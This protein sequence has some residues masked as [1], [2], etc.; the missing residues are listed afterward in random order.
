MLFALAM[1]C[2]I[3]SFIQFVKMCGSMIADS[4]AIRVYNTKEYRDSDE[5]GARLSKILKHFAKMLVAVFL[6]TGFMILTF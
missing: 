1:I 5:R 4:V 6:A 2:Y 3:Y